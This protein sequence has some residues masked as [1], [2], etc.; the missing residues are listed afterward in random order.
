VFHELTP[1][2][3]QNVI[4]NKRRR[5]KLNFVNENVRIPQNTSLKFVCCALIH[6]K[7]AL[8]QEIGSND[9]KNLCCL[10][11]TSDIYE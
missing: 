1:K 6:D 11:E 10:E 7:S 9:D 4:A 3:L 2:R 5:L 8:V